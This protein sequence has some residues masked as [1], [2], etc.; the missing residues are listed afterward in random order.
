MAR[1]VNKIKFQECLDILHQEFRKIKDPRAFFQISLSDILMSSFVVF[2]LKHPS[3][4][5]FEDSIQQD[6]IK[7]NLRA[8]VPGPDGK[9]TA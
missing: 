1:P 3:L 5:N 7:S 8:A 4:L 9:N 2:N 6:P